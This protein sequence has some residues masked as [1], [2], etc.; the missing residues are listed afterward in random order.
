MKL[1]LTN[2][3]EGGDADFI[4]FLR[5][6]ESAKFTVLVGIYDPTLFRLFGPFVMSTVKKKEEKKL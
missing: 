5:A 2:Q 4:E 1:W 3:T 6:S